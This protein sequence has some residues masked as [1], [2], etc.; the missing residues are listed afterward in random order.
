MNA[1][2]AQRV[3]IVDDS[4]DYAKMLERLLKSK[5]GFT[6]VTTCFSLE[7]GKQII[8]GGERFALYFVDYNFPT[9]G[10]GTDFLRHLLEANCLTDAVSFLIT[11]EPT[12][13]NMEEATSAGAVGVVAKPFDIP[14]LLSQIELAKR[15]LFSDKIDY[16]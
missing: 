8:E 15:K 1:L 3:L 5:A 10:K 2:T 9:G 6:D 16:F 13:K 7:D 4:K 12:L 11:S 14:Q